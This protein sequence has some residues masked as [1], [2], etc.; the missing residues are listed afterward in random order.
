[1][2]NRELEKKTEITEAEVELEASQDTVDENVAGAE[3][4]K[5]ITDEPKKAKKEKKAK[6][7][8]TKDNAEKGSKKAIFICLIAAAIVVV[9]GIVAAGVL[10]YLGSESENPILP[11][12]G[13][14]QPE[15]EDGTKFH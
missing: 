11:G 5:D 1:M 14:E 15:I 9:L 4:F 2:D 10:W 3:Q 13:E 8:K 6:A 7:K 12:D